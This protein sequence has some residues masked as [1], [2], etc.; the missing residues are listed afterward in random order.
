[1]CS[2]QDILGLHTQ[3]HSLR[4]SVTWIHSRIRKLMF[5][6]KC[7]QSTEDGTRILSHPCIH[8]STFISVP[9][10]PHT[11]TV[12]KSNCPLKWDSW[13]VLNKC[14][15]CN[16]QKDG[17]APT[18]RPSIFHL[19]QTSL[20]SPSLF[21]YLSSSFKVHDCVLNDQMFILSKLN[22]ENWWLC[23]LELNANARMLLSREVVPKPRPP[24]PVCEFPAAGPQTKEMIHTLT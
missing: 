23:G 9:P 22:T 2:W 13:Q 10:P 3:Y 21:F 16:I 7:L 17:A 15:R 24:E 6:W 20:R 12:W 18:R 8:R 19:K 11:H 1:M 4:S 14:W 5:T